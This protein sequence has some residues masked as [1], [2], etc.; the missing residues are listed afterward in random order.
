M[1]SDVNKD[2]RHKAKAKDSTNWKRK[3]KV[4]AEDLSFKVKAKAKNITAHN[5][6]LFRLL[7]R[8]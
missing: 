5:A 6:T 2:L 1:F 7:V 4:K 3:A 8:I